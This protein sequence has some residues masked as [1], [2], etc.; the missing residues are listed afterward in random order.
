M[1]REDL[2]I[3]QECLDSINSIER[4]ISDL[5]ALRDTPATKYLTMA[6]S[7]IKF[8]FPLSTELLV[9]FINDTI[10]KLQNDVTHFNN[11]IEDL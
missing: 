7:S 8:D 5:E 9:K 3:G 10:D 4:K 11:E 2:K 6:S 1:T